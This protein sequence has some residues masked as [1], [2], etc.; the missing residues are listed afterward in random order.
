MISCK[1]LVRILCYKETEKLR[2]MRPRFFLSLILFAIL[3]VACSS[4][5]STAAL[6]IKV[7]Q[8]TASP[9]GTFATT[10]FPVVTSRGPHLEATDPKTVNMASGGLQFIEFFEFW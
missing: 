1:T 4:A 6:A 7:S 5:T 8:A 10:P 2:M 3:L 9:I